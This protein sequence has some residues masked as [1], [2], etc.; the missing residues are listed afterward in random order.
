MTGLRRV[1]TNLTPSTQRELE[2]VMEQSEETVTEVV[3]R[4][5]RR[6]ARDWRTKQAG[7][8]IVHIDKNGKG[9]EVDFL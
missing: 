3:N 9:I 4:A 7:G 1:A 6:Y 5:I 8:R 2:Y